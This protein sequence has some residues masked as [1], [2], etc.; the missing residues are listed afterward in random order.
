MKDLSVIIPACNEHPQATF[1]LQSIWDQ[2]ERTHYDWETIIVDNNST[3]DTGTYAEKKYWGK[4]GRHK[5]IRYDKRTSQWGAIDAALEVATGEVIFHFDAHVVI[6]H[7]LFRRQMGA[8][9]KNPDIP[10]LYTPVVWMGDTPKHALYG[11]HL[12]NFHNN[13]WGDW[14]GRKG[15]DSEPFMV[16]I[17]GM[18]GSA[19]RHDYLK[20]ING[21]PKQLQ[22]YGGG[23]QWVAFLAW[24]MGLSCWSHPRTYLYH[25]HAPRG[26]RTGNEDQLFNKAL[27]MYALGGEEWWDSVVTR[28]EQ[29]WGKP[30]REAGL[31]IAAMARVAAQ[32]DRQRVISLSKY[33]LDEVLETKPWEAAAV[34]P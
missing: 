19:F 11:Y 23:E 28:M 6:S 1:T 30:Y 2:L 17:S 15:S 18:A 21:W 31:K 25:Y 8:F 3:D 20:Q 9:Q 4:K 34:V 14:S 26:Y 10:V 12:D 24:M 13:H 22:V 16:P 32:E 29:T 5:V 33:T 7:G 27:V